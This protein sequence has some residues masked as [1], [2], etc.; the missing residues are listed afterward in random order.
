MYQNSIPNLDDVRKA[1]AF[2]LT[3]VFRFEGKMTKEEAAEGISRLIRESG[4]TI[5][6]EWVTYAEKP[7]LEQPDDI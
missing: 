2:I 6:V 7:T 5:P 4:G 3:P 1:K